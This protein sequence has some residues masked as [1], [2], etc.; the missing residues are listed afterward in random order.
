[1]RFR[2]TLPDINRLSIIAAVIMLAFALTQVI[3]F[4]RQQISFTVF[5]VIYELFIDFSTII[6][7]LTASLA[8]AGVA[9]LIQSNPHRKQY[10]YRWSYIRHW[11][12]PVFTT[13]VIS[14]TLNTLDSGIFWW[15]MFGVGSLLLMAVFIAEYNVSVADNIHHPLAM[16]G[17][18]ALSF[19]LF[20]LLAIVVSSAQ[21]R[22][23]LQLPLL[24]TSAIVVISRSFYLRL[25]KWY[26]IWA[27]VVSLIISEMVVGFHYLPL[28]P[29]QFGLLLVGIAYSLTSVVSAIKE[30]RKGWNFWA[31]PIGMLVLV[32]LVSFIW[33]S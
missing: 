12:V 15:V 9:W 3:S 32:I 1:M 2:D 29:I 28:S 5:G 18:T 25:G 17:L 7:V 14:V 33:P 30:E 4:P 24:A 22:L 31:E 8:A 27:V 20:L 13:L 26:M 10:K 19:A 11:I 21:M 23:Y 6:T 16:I